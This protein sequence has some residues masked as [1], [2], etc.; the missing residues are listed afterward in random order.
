MAG[1]RLYECVKLVDAGIGLVDDRSACA[2]DQDHVSVMPCALVYID[3]QGNGSPNCTSVDSFG[4][5]EQAIT[6]N[7]SLLAARIPA[8]TI[9][10][11]AREQVEGYLADVNGSARLKLLELKPSLTLPKTTRFY[12]AHFKLDLLQQIGE[13][14]PKGTL[15]LLLDTDMVAL[16]SFDQGVLQ[17]CYRCGAGAFDISDQE[18]FA[19][20]AERVISD[21]EMVAGRPLENP[22]WFGG[23][24]L[25][26]SANFI[27]ELVPRARECFNRYRLVTDQLSHNGDEAFVSAA[28]NLLADD[29]HQIIDVGSYRVV[30]RH[31]SGN[32]HRDLRWFKHCS[33]LHLPDRKRVLERQARTRRFN[34]DRIW[35]QLVFAHLV[36]L[37]TVPV[38]RLIRTKLSALREHDD[39]RSS[40]RADGR[41]S[42]RQRARSSFSPCVGTDVSRDD[43][44]ALD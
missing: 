41:A 24:C 9:A 20:G 2:R 43:S 18:F 34:V 31:W 15:A 30:G 13:S 19:Y 3:P 42:H 32:T 4:Y 12:A 35:R 33:L 37:A 29:G 7:R 39:V 27:A 40:G 10:T 21:L 11:N 5:V 23:E 16:R 1:A 28:L 17:R 26:A 8:L 36:G 22:R 14:L 38:K 44:D 25:F 6:L